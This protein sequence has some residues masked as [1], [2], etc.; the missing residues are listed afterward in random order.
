[1]MSIT[2]I[3]VMLSRA[4]ASGARVDEVLHAEVDIKDGTNSLIPNINCPHI[5]FDKVSFSYNKQ[6]T[7]IEDISFKLYKGQTLGIIGSTGSGKTTL[8]NLLMRFYESDSGDILYYGQNIKDLKVK[9]LRRTIG[10]VL[11][12]D[13][14]FSESIY[15]NIQFNRSH[16]EKMDIEMAT[17]IAQAS[18]ICER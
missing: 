3:F 16:I 12:Q 10:L 5:V 8:I 1:M 6:K 7:N 2:R 15:D 9:E 14:I 13:L 18:F 4:Q 17:N 11:Q